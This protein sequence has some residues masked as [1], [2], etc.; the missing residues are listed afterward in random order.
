MLAQTQECKHGAISAA[1]DKADGQQGLRRRWQAAGEGDLGSQGLE[2]HALVH[3]LGGALVPG[4]IAARV[5]QSLGVA[6]RRAVSPQ[7][8]LR[9]RHQRPRLT[10]TTSGQA[11]GGHGTWLAMEM[12]SGDS[13]L[14]TVQAASELGLHKLNQPLRVTAAGQCPSSHRASLS[15]ST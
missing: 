11:E 13:S 7:V 5:L 2:E 8:A 10:G 15:L 4:R 14:P 12:R 3:D 6:V 9:L 1:L